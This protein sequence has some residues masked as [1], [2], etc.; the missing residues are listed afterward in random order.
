MAERASNAL[1][2]ALARRLIS[3]PPVRFLALLALCGAYVQGGLTKARDVEGIRAETAPWHDLTP[4]AST[5]T[6]LHGR[7]L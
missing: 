3:P 1:L 7:D 5:G 4:G 6:S 2:A